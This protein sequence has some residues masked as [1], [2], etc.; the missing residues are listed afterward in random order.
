VVDQEDQ[1]VLLQER[2]ELQVAVAVVQ[3]E[4]AAHLV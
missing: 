4:E 2:L 1:E 3:P